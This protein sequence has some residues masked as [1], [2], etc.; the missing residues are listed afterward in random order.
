MPRAA[1][2]LRRSTDEQADSLDTQRDFAVRFAASRGFEIVVEYCDTASGAEW[3]K[4]PGLFRL[5]A[6]AKAKAFEIVIVRDDSRIGRDTLR[7]PMFLAS[8]AEAGA[9]VV[10]YATGDTLAIDTPIAQFMA[11]ARGFAHATE[12]AA[13]ASGEWTDMWSAVA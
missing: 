11:S 2:Y 3:V 5:L 6:D 9:Q 7:T 8:L 4:R 13:I 12:R 10:C 1:L